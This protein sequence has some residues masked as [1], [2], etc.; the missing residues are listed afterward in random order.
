MAEA[1]AGVKEAYLQLS[2]GQAIVPLRSRIDIKSHNGISLVMPA[3][4][5][6]KDDLAVKIVS[7]YPDNVERNEP[8]IYASVIVLD[9]ESGRP[10]ALL[11]GGTITAIRTGAASGAATDVLARKDAHIAAIF[12]SGVQARTQLEAVATI[13]SLSEVRVYSLSQAQA[14]Q[15]AGEMAGFGPIPKAIKVVDSPEEAIDGAD[16]ICT[17]TTSKRPVFNGHDL[18]PG[19]HINAIGSFTPEMQEVDAETVR[20]SLVFVDSREAALEEAGDLL[21][22]MAR[23]EI[24]RDTIFAELG[25][26]IGGQKKGRTDS[27]Q[28]TYFKSVGIAIQDAVAGR[29]ALENAIALDLGT[30]ISLD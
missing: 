24:P 25:E 21:V 16:I 22:P 1:I 17:A 7:V 19:A 20:R 9:A 23:G 8:V 12:G 28:I 15:F 2:S 4:L 18:E 26:V 10:V 29:I 30:V 14:R 5:S 13:R 6:Q 27:G 11:E 3:Y